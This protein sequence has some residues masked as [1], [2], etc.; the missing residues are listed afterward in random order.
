MR[1]QSSALKLRLLLASCAIA[2][3]ITSAA[4]QNQQPASAPVPIMAP[5]PAQGSQSAT[6][7]QSLFEPRFGWVGTTV[8]QLPA[9]MRKEE[10]AATEANQI[11][12]SQQA[13]RREVVGS[14]PMTQELIE[15]MSSL[16]ITPIP[17]PR[18]RPRKP[19]S[20]RTTNPSAVGYP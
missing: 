17:L 3:I 13:L 10:E 2:G 7:P 18:P 20:I 6:V 14:S 11:S 9:V 19:P 16:E 15:S 4:W 5:E 8:P 1:N 12:E